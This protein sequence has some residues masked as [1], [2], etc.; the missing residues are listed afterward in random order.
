M[1]MK[2]TNITV[3]D[4]NPLILQ[5]E[6]RDTVRFKD[7]ASFCSIYSRFMNYFFLLDNEEESGFLV[8]ESQKSSGGQTSKSDQVFLGTVPQDFFY[9][10]PHK[11]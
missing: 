5:P 7:S 10:P 8:Y 6:I 4:T 3:F 11:P 9:F 2:R 1:T